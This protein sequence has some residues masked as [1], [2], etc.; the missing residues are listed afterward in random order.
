MG[1]S[2]LPE[3]VTSLVC[4][5]GRKPEMTAECWWTACLYKR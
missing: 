2:L 5:I 1:A 3:N 4:V